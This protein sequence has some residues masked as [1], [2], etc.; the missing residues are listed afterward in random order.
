MPL[1]GRDAA[2]RITAQT[3]TSSTDVAATR[4]TGLGA[5]ATPTG[6]VQITS[7]AQRHLDPDGVHSLWRIAAG[8]TTLVPSTDY[9]INYVQGIFQWKTGDPSTGTYQADIEYL[10]A[11]NIAGGQEWTLNVEQEA[12]EVT[13][14]GSSGW[15]QYQPNLAGAT[16]TINRYWV[17]SSFLDLMV[18]NNAKF[19]VELV[20][21]SAAGW[22]YEGFAFLAQTGVNTAVDAIVSES[23]NLTIDGQLYF[24]T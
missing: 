23:L 11:S 22:K 14:F 6:Y 2:V 15:R 10:T 19:L 12:F 1:A 4:S 7:T 18:A 21:N 13:E 9:N 3:A 20:V 8:S 5:G 16:A 24:T 17:D